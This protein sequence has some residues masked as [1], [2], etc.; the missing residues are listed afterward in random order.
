MARKRRRIQAGFCYH[1]MLRGN[2]GECIFKDDADRIRFCQLLQYASEKHQLNIHGFCLMGNHVHFIIQPRTSDLTAGMHSLAFRYAQ[3]FNKKYNRRGYLYQGRYKAVLVQPGAYLQRL[4][5]YVHLN[6]VR[7]GMVC[8]PEDYRWSSHS[9]YVGND[10]YTWLD[11]AL[12]LNVFGGT[13]SDGAERLFRYTQM[14][15]KEAADEAFEIRMSLSKG[16]YG[17]N[18]FL[19]KWCPI[20]AE[21]EAGSGFHLRSANEV[22][23]ETIVEIVCRRLET[24][25]EDVCSEKRASQLVQAR[26]VIASLTRKFGAGTMTALGNYISRDPTSLAKLARKGELDAE[27]KRITDEL[28]ALLIGRTLTPF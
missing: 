27:V 3:F 17:D 10:A 19:E 7:A 25:K 8:K 15:D 24:T 28:F 21:N 16:A 9:A 13:S 23:L 1:A 26:A 12:I 5:R 6:P 4:V 22:S 18:E 14:N 20:L 11:Q 2:G